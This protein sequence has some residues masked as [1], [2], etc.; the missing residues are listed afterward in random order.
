MLAAV[1]VL[2]PALYG[3]D[4]ALA[5][6]SIIESFKRGSGCELTNEQKGP[7]A[8]LDYLPQAAWPHRAPLAAE[9]DGVSGVTATNTP[10]RDTGTHSSPIAA[11][12]AT[13]AALD[14]FPSQPMFDR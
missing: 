12:I 11:H 9:R 6:A 1:P 13:D 2:A 4:I 3:A 7:T 10:I 8:F 14:R 5:R